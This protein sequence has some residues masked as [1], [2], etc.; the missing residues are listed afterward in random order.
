MS[1]GDEAFLVPAGP[2]ATDKR[3]A[4]SITSG[5]LDGERTEL[6]QVSKLRVTSKPWL[7][8]CVSRF[9]L[10]PSLS[11]STP[12]AQLAL[13]ASL[14]EARSTCSLGP[15]GTLGTTLLVV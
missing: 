2:R 3:I 14:H 5:Y 12:G 9:G 11:S 13:A 10:P 1:S 7:L 6:R 8:Y 4:G 15:T